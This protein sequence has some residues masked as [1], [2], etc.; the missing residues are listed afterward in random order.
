MRSQLD[1]IKQEHDELKD[2]YHKVSSELRMKKIENKDLL[3]E[4]CSN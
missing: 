2:S 4:R 1:K 3:R